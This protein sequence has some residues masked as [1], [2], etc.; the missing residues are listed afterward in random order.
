MRSNCGRRTTGLRRGATVTVL[1]FLAL[2][3]P[4]TLAH[5]APLLPDLVSDAPVQSRAPQVYTDATGSRLLLRMDGYVHN[6]GAGALEIR[7]SANVSGTMTTVTQMVYDSN[8]AVAPVPVL[9]NPAPRVLFE[10]ADGH[11]HFH[12]RHAMRYSLW[13]Q[14]RTAEVAP[15]QKVGF[16]LVD[17]QR[18]ESFARTT[19]VYTVAANAF[20]QQNNPTASSVVMGVSGGWRDIYS[21]LLAFQ[22]VD[23]SDV[24][25]G[26]YWLRADADPDRV[27]VE[28]NETNAP[29]YATALS[30]VNGYLA[31]PVNA[32]TV[33][34]LSS[35][36]ITLKATKYD[37]TWSATPGAV[38]YKIVTAPRKGSLNQPVGSWFSS[39]QLKYTPRFGQSGADSFTF[40]ARDASSAFPLNPRTATATITISGLF[41]SA[42]STTARTSRTA[43]SGAPE[44]ASTS[45]TVQLSVVGAGSGPVRWSVNGIP[46]GNAS[47]G[48]VSPDGVF[49][50]PAAAPADGRVVLGAASSAGDVA[51]TA[52]RIVP[53]PVSRPAPSLVTPA[54]RGRGL[55]KIVLAR[56]QRSLIAG[57]T[58]GS[59]GRVRL[60]ATRNGV[61][62]GS[63]ST[64]ARRGTASICKMTLSRAIAAQPL[65]C[66]IP[67][68]TGLKLPGVKV[69]A[70]LVSGGKVID[71][72]TASPR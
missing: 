65:V 19:A 49:Q 67:R 48:T 63:C 37:D 61:Q 47:V 56:H 55:S 2:V 38:Q 42:A 51:R 40:A 60:I 69:T 1:T 72:T 53:A 13:N 11:N 31:Q 8:T 18:I 43:I 5:A 25:P 32:G 3:V 58:P 10:G 35:K 52:V 50:A 59:S 71:T 16:C 30:V 24:A 45:S 68:T 6:A 20:C 12:L 4:A 64:A 62:I 41:S 33:G 34:T 14:G 27:V 70:H 54:T 57:V 15:S 46:G 26:Q 7:G 39:S 44:R 23:I 28:A 66:K 36:T 29:G 21:A 9:S 22:W 17:S